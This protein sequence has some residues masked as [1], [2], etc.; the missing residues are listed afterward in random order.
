MIGPP[1]RCGLFSQLPLLP[2]YLYIC[3]SDQPLHFFQLPR[4]KRGIVGSYKKTGERSDVRNFEVIYCLHV[5]YFYGLTHCEK[6]RGVKPSFK[7]GN[8]R[9]LQFRI[10]A[11]HWRYTWLPHL[12]AV[13]G[14]GFYLLP[15]LLPNQFFNLSA[16]SLLSL[17]RFWPLSYPNFGPRSVWH[18]PGRVF[19]PEITPLPKSVFFSVSRKC[20]TQHN[21]VPKIRSWFEIRSRRLWSPSSTNHGAIQA[22]RFSNSQILF[23]IP[24]GGRSK[25]GRPKRNSVPFFPPNHLQCYFAH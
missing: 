9:R 5:R 13:A 20:M 19:S 11:V 14:I 7:P 16:S 1:S 8:C 12:I 15:L 24:K 25:H 6:F 4:L 22:I 10:I 21:F 2:P 23:V 3:R 17:K 18:F